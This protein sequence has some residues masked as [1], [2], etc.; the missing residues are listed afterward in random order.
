MPRIQAHVF[1]SEPSEGTL[2]S[3]AILIAGDEPY[4]V[5]K[6]LALVLGR[7]LS[8]PGADQFDLEKRDAS[9]ISA[10]DLD[11]LTSTLPFVNDRRVVVLKNVPSIGAEARDRLK[12][13]LESEPVGLC[14]IGTGGSTMRGNLYDVWEKHGARI[15]CELPRKSPRSKQVDFD[16]AR[17]L[18]QRAREDFGKTLDK[19]AAA[20]LAEVAA[21]LQPL[22]AELEKV[23][24]Y[25]GDAERIRREDVAEICSGGAVGTV[26]EWC[27]AVGAGDARRS[28]GL[29]ADL[30]AAGES[31]YRLVP[32]LAT[33]FARLG[34]AVEA[35]GRESAITSAL[36]GRSWPAMVRSLA[37]QA[38][39]RDPASV[40]RALDLLA[41]ADLMLKSTGHAEDFVLQRHL[42]EILDAA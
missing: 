19:D 10:A 23:A 39:G 17:W 4:L 5:D 33:H 26:W 40:A 41:E 31:A 38:R 32:L 8:A 34:V 6:A 36:P 20:A 29:L 12:A 42:V 2:V 7:V 22:Y 1:L 18:V 9:E 24:M 30:L 14:L 35:G 28:L 25:V 13:I 15:V 37:S 11:S 21:E 16:F 27:D 3:P